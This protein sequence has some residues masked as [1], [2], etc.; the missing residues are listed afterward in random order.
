MSETKSEIAVYQAEIRPA[1]TGGPARSPG[2][3]R[4][5]CQSPRETTRHCPVSYAG[6]SK[7]FT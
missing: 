5:A 2:G 3:V 4:Q 1:C 6:V 7:R